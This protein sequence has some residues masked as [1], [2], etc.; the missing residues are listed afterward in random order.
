[1]VPIVTADYSVS[2]TLHTV[3]LSVDSVRTLYKQVP[4]VKPEKITQTLITFMEPLKQVLNRELKKT[5]FLL[6]LP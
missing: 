1:M 2:M 3:S 4:L 6:P 5:T